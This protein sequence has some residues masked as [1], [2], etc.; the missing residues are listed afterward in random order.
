MFYAM[1]NE[2]NRII[3]LS[4][5][6]FEDVADNCSV[7]EMDGDMPEIFDDL[8]KYIVN[9]S[10]EIEYDIANYVEQ[11]IEELTNSVTTED[12]MDAILELGSIVASM[13]EGV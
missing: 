6:G 10:G 4:V 7:I 12:L 8:E 13:Q 11:K 1:T 9:E 5:F 2:N 3:G